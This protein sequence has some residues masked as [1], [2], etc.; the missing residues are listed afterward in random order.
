MTGGV[1]GGSGSDASGSA[2]DLGGSRQAGSVVFGQLP[3]VVAA[4]VVAFVVTVDVG[5]YLR[6]ASQ[7]QAAADGAALAAAVAAHPRTSSPADPASVVAAHL[8][9]TGVQVVRCECRRGAGHVVVVTRMRVAGL[10]MRRIWA[11]TVDATAVADATW[12]V[13]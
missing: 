9:D 13:P 4:L 10:V 3:L 7:A 12:V 6:A 1:P 5:A 8:R 2:P 11:P